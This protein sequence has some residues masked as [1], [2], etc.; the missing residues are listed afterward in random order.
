MFQGLSTSDT[1]AS[2]LFI[3]TPPV[4]PSMNNG[5]PEVQFPGTA[6]SL[7][8]HF[9]L[10]TESPG[11]STYRPEWLITYFQPLIESPIYGEQPLTV[12]ATRSAYAS[13]HV[14]PA[15]IP[16]LSEYSS[17]SGQEHLY[18]ENV[19]SAHPSYG[20]AADLRTSMDNAFH[21]TSESE[22]ER[23]RERER[24]RDV[25]YAPREAFDTPPAR[26]SFDELRSA[27]KAR[28]SS[29]RGLRVEADHLVARS[30]IESSPPTAKRGRS[31]PNEALADDM[32]DAASDSTIRVNRRRPKPSVSFRDLMVGLNPS[33]PT[34][35]STAGTSSLISSILDQPVD[36]PRSDD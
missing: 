5:Q 2:P 15:S 32:S 33:H 12:E 36:D 6:L 1:T 30:R 16:Q 17:V 19:H 11:S 3:S 35:S 31:S 9:E 7:D 29:S 26:P 25:G 27:T 4:V 20:V 28:T 14:L 21:A 24:E 23:G 34:P 22:V 13:D 8:T 18:W 10:D